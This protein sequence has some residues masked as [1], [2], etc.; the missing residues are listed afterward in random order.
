M[1]LNNYSAPRQQREEKARK[2]DGLY[3]DRECLHCE[4]FFD[5]DG[6]RRGVDS[7]LN[8]QERK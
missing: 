1:V 8:F 3:K 4:K 7:C 6:K 2:I 5:C